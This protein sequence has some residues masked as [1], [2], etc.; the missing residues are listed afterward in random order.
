M[1][2]K[3]V[4]TV[5]ALCAVAAIVFALWQADIINFPSQLKQKPPKKIEKTC[6]ISEGNRIVTLG[7][8]TKNIEKLFGTPCDAIISE[9]GFVWNIYHNNFKNYIQI[10]IDNDTVVAMY[11]NSPDLSF[12]GLTVGSTKDEAHAILQKPIDGIVKGD[13]RYLSNGSDDN[14]NFEVFE[15][16]GAYVTLFYDSLANNSITSVNIIDYDVEQNFK[17]LYAEPTQELKESFEKQSFYITNATRAREGLKPYLPQE[18]L[19]EIAFAHSSDMVQNDYFS[20]TDLNGD[21]VLERGL[22]HQIDFSAI[23][24]NLAMGAQNSL[25][26]HE[27]L[28]NSEGHRKN[29]LADFTHLGTGVAFKDNGSPYLTQNFLK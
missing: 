16:D 14:A 3:I 29:I 10:G 7:M 5:L 23:G 6:T 28:M 12:K 20:H 2:K 18:Q 17:R 11:S 27:L 9:Y 22:N 26:L 8:N 4:A 1:S 25:Y 19:N 15:T 21:T 13:T 24:E